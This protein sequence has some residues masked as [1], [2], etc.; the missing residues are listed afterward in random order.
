M[1]KRIASDRVICD[2]A[3]SVD[4]NAKYDEYQRGLAPV[5]YKYFDKMSS[6]AN[7]SCSVVMH[8][9]KSAFKNEVIA[10]QQLAEILHK[11]VVRKFEKRKLY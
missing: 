1:P 3:F 11:P 2:K 5:I 10:N 4:K 6:G 8:T 7:P 9:N